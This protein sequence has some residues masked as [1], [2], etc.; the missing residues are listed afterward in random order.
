MAAHDPLDVN[1]GKGIPYGV[2]PTICVE[3]KL[4][5]PNKFGM[6]QGWLTITKFY[7]ADDGSQL[8]YPIPGTVYQIKAIAFDPDTN[9][10][11]DP[12]WPKDETEISVQ[13]KVQGWIGQN[14]SVVPD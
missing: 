5:A 9:L 2:F 6:D 11:P 12:Q 1:S 4:D 3:V 7:N 10:T 14:T 8:Q 13:V